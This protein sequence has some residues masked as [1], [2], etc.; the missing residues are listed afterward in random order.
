MAFS[1]NHFNNTSSGQADAPKQWS[2]KSS[3]DLI[4]T[5]DDSGYFNSVTGSLSL[6]DLIYIRDSAD[7][8]SER[9]VSSAT[10]AATVTTAAYAYTGTIQTADIADSAVTAAKIAAAVAGAGLIGGAGTALA[11][12]VDESTLSIPVDTVI[13]KAL[14]VTSAQLAAAIPRTVTVAVTSA[15]FKA[16]YATP[17][18][19][20][21]A[22]GVNTL[23]LVHDVAFEYKFVSAQYTGGGAIA[24]QYD[25]TANGAGTAGCVTLA[26]ATVNA[27]AA[28]STVGMQGALTSA[29]GTTTVNKGLY[30]SNATAAFA[31]GDGTINLHVTYS[32]VTTSI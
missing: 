28:N 25:S 14:G 24:V 29:A 12:Q 20:V 7:A 22:A 9:T 16:A 10:G 27:Y 11:V 23:H 3:T 26:A 6:G 4:T 21:A 8:L 15:Q 19:L 32:T 1:L 30:L 18:L 31:T 17:L 5:I 13:I 2:Y